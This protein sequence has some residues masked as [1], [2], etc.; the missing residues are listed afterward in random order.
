LRGVE[1]P[2]MDSNVDQKKLLDSIRDA[3][4]KFEEEECVQFCE[5]ALEKG[6]D[7]YLAINE[8]LAAGMN[9][10]GELYER[11]EYFVPE[12]LLCSDALYAGLDIL[13]PHVKADRTGVCGKIV[14][15]VVEGDIHDI[16]KNLVKTMMVAA[17][18]EVTDL[19]NNVKLDRFLEEQKKIKADV[20]ALSTLMTSSMLAMQK[21][22][23]MLKDKAPDA[24]I[25]VGG[26]PLTKET[27]RSYGADGYAA[28]ASSAVKE[29]I[30]LLKKR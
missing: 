18:F 20:V 12:L 29:L 27:A 14:I 24:L 15:G 22:I 23:Q 4:L 6:V 5:E 11:A 19:G 30:G 10:A 21:V 17:G 3:V 1:K 26:A 8:G 16:G 9:M 28:D 25:I 2:G 13:R 7:P